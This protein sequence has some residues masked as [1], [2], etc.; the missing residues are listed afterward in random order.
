M[1]DKNIQEEAEAVETE[2]T[3]FDSEL[4]SPRSSFS[5]ADYDCQRE[6]H[7]FKKM[8][9]QM[10]HLCY[11]Q[12][13]GNKMEIDVY[14]DMYTEWSKFMQNLGACMSVAFRDVENKRKNILDN[15]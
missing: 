3:E 14:C 7:D 10:K 2:S 1:L 8:V 4:S 5:L 12:D 13:Q 9:A 15:R 11:Q 6:E